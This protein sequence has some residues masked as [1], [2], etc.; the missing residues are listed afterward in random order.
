MLV[1]VLEGLDETDDLI[2]VPAD[3]Q[4]VD[5][6]LAKDTLFINDVRSAESDTCV[7]TVFDEAAVLLRDRLGDIG[8]HG[9]AHGTKTT[10]LTSLHG[11]FSVGEVRVDGTT[12][13]LG[14]HGFELGA[15]VLEL[16]DLGWAHEGEVERP[17]EED[18]VLTSEL[19]QVDS[20]ELVLPP[21]LS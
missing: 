8:D 13:D 16:A 20:L 11:V 10:T 4:V 2:D 21:G 7:V 17:E 1:S 3:G 14:V 15:L 19:F 6:V 18:N 9:E 12:N 5:A